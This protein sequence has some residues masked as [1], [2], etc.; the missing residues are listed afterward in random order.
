MYK[1]TLIRPPTDF[2]KEILQSRREYIHKVMKSKSLQ[3]TILYPARLS[4]K[5]GEIK[6]ITDKQKLKEFSTTK[7]ALQEMLKG[8]L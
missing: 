5:F 4:F 2:P 1:G 3:P 8:L 6:N 7:P